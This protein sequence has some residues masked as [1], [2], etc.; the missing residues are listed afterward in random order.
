MKTTLSSGS[1]IDESLRK[2]SE[3]ILWLSNLFPFEVKT[4]QILK[5]KFKCESDAIV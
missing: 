1:D 3:Q 4:Y 5:D 2:I